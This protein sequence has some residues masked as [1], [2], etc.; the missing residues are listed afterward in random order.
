MS[1]ERVLSSDS[2]IKLSYTH[3]LSLS[4]VCV[5][6]GKDRDNMCVLGPVMIAR[7]IITVLLEKAICHL[8]GGVVS[9]ILS[10]GLIYN[11]SSVM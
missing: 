1:I 4:D 11:N 2:V 9:L 8:S 6:K 10:D 7:D 3:T 5:V